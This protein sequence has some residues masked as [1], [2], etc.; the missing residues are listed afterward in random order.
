MIQHY[1]ASLKQA[2]ILRGFFL[3]ILFGTIIFVLAGIIGF[4]LQAKSGAL[5]T[6][7]LQN[8]KEQLLSS[9][10]LAQALTTD[11]QGFLAILII[12]ILILT[13]GS[14]LL[15]SLT[16]SLIW[17][18]ILNKKFNKKKFWRWNTFL[19]ILPF[20]VLPYFMVY[21]FIKSIVNAFL[22]STTFLAVINAFLSLALIILFPILIFILMYSFTHEY[23]VWQSFTFAYELIQKKWSKIKC[24]YVYALGTAI[25]LNII[26]FGLGK[27]VL[28]PYITGVLFLLYIAWLRIYVAKMLNFS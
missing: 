26:I 27:I 25:I 28:I 21:F 2:K 1:I 24:L 12:G 10:E 6:I 15:F 11:L 8:L 19:I 22:S 9:P 5:R 14:L 16:R 23:R 3:D 7:P 4:L 20:H 18:N 17:N 13:V